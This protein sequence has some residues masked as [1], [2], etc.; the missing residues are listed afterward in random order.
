ML[1]NEFYSP[2][3]HGAYDFY[4]LGDFGLESGAV[5]SNCQIAYAT[6]GTLNADKSNAILFPHMFSG[7]SAH[8]QMYAGAGMALDPE[9]YFIVFPNMLGNGLSSSPHNSPAPQAMSQFPQVSI[10]DDVVAQQRLLGEQFGIDSLELVVGWSMGAQ[11]TFEW[12]VRFPD[13]VKRAAAIGG[14]AKGT[15]HNHLL[16]GNAMR[17][18]Q[19]DSAWAGGDYKTAHAATAGLQLLAHFF[20]MIGLSKEFYAA[21]QWRSVGFDSYDN[22]MSGFWEAWFT[23]MDANALLCLLSKWQRA[24]VSRHTDG[25]LAAALARIKAVVYNMPFEKDL[26]FTVAECAAEHALTPR[27]SLKPIPTAWGHFG[28]LGVA[29]EDKAFIDATLQELLALP[30]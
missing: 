12:A 10:G 3:N 30:A 6:L 26:M 23:P 17:M 13:Q 28:M 7:T 5:I 9:K 8:M 20:A 18:I 19:S 2:A 16:V 25:D 4:A 11:Q 14:T 1:D 27:S 29:P 22:F 21:E 15:A 24:D